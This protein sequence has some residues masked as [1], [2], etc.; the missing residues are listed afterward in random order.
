MTTM[1]SVRALAYPRTC[2]PAASGTA[3]HRNVLLVETDRGAEGIALHPFL[4][5]QDWDKRVVIHWED[6]H[7]SHTFTVLEIVADGA[8]RFEFVREDEPSG[9]VTL[10]PLTFERFER[11]YRPLDPEAGNVPGFES[12][13]QFRRWFLPG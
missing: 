13:E 2:M 11:E 9:R 10:T 1:D 5:C 7:G 8:H 6:D 3:E 4:L 12:E